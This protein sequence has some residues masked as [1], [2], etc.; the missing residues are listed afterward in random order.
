MSI[1]GGHAEPGRIRGGPA[2]G[3]TAPE[4]CGRGR[5][6]EDRGVGPER[7]SGHPPLFPAMA[8][9]S[10]FPAWLT[11]GLDVLFPPA[12]AACGRELEPWGDAPPGG[13]AGAHGLCGA[14]VAEMVSA[15]ARCGRC[16]AE[17]TA[18]RCRAC[19]GRGADHDGIVV[20][21]DYGGGLRGAVLR[22]KRPAGRRLAENLARLLHDRH[23]STIA[24]WKVDVVVPVPMHW[25]RRL[26]RGTNAAGTVARSVAR[27]A[28][29]PCADLLRRSRPTVPQNSL[30]PEG[31][32]AN[33]RD[34]FAASR[35]GVAGH[36]VLL[37]D[38]VLTTGGTVAACRQTL[39]R[40]GAA[41]VFV[42]VIARAGR[43][44]DDG[45]PVSG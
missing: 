19:H 16:G 20:L 29:L 39:V 4:V 30:P 5:G 25:R 42:A 7:Q 44:G 13:P 6:G 28:G 37:V 24:A 23:G 34:A 38:D 3:A 32:R 33:V 22:A 9:R 10:A 36:R 11:A 1:G 43:G 2:G 35:R 8:E 27:D 17:T 15:T 26:L 18:D 14:G 21:G 41:A 31:R 12:C 40:A 45:D